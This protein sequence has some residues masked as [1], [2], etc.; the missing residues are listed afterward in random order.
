MEFYKRHLEHAVLGNVTISPAGRTSGFEV[1]SPG[2]EDLHLPVRA[3]VVKEGVL[4]AC[5]HAGRNLYAP[6]NPAGDQSPPGG[7]FVEHLVKSFGREIL[8]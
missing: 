3:V 1:V 6:V 5:G 8:A 7:Q 4:M 2:V